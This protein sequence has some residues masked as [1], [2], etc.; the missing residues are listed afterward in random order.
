M[1][2]FGFNAAETIG[3][4]RLCRPG[5]VIGPQQNFL[6]DMEKRMWKEGEQFRK[7]QASPSKASGEADDRA[8]FSLREQMKSIA[9]GGN[10]NSTAVRPE[11]QS[12]PASPTK[13]PSRGLSLGFGSKPKSGFGRR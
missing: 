10:K 1:K 2:H 5:S 9:L 13:A 12:P 7:K 11:S 6:H 3:Y 4:L 8:S